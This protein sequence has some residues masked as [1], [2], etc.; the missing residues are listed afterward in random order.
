MKVFGEAKCYADIFCITVTPRMLALML[1][2]LWVLDSNLAYGVVNVYSN[3]LVTPSVLII[4][5][6]EES[7]FISLSQQLLIWPN[8]PQKA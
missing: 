4:L 2:V 7:K 1:L 3:E 8:M 6:A 5:T